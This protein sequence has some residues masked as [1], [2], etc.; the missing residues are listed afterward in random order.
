MLEEMQNAVEEREMRAM[1]DFDRERRERE[2]KEQEQRDR[3]QKEIDDFQTEQNL[4]RRH[5]LA[6]E[7]E[8]KARMQHIWRDRADLLVEEEL[9]ERQDARQTAERLQRFQLLQAQEKRMQN[10][11]EKRQDIEEGIQLQEALKEEQ[12]M[13]HSYVNSVMNEYVRKGRGADIVKAAAKRT[14]VKT[15]Q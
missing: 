11:H 7:Q 15:P 14:K 12:Q 2:A 4:K 13:Y 3:R 9:E 8:E 5:Q 1:R 10:F 6:R